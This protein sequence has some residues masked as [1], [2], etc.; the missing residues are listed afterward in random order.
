MR[1]SVKWGHLLLLPGARPHLLGGEREDSEVL[2]VP[3]PK[4]WRWGEMTGFP[5]GES[6]DQG[7][8]PEWFI[9]MKYPLVPILDAECP[10]LK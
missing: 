5:C 1:R 4:E 10:R 9:K 6:R 3:L 2:W 8:G 7:C